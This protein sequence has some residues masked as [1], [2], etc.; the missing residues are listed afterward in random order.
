MS[1]KFSSGLSLIVFLLFQ[2]YLAFAQSNPFPQ[3][4]PYSQSFEAYTGST[5]AYLPGWQGWTITGSTST[6]FPTASPSGNQVQSMGTNSTVS[7][8]VFD[9]NGKIG[10]LNSAS[11]LKTICLSINTSGSASIQVSYLVATQRTQPIDRVGA[12]GLQFRIGNVGNFVDIGN[13]YQNINSVANTTGTGMLNPITITVSLPESC[14]NLPEVQLRWVYKDIS[15]AGGRPSFSIDEVTICTPP[16]WYEDADGD[17]YG[18]ASNSLSYCTQPDGYVANS[19]DCNDLDAAVNTGSIEICN[20]ID[21]NCSGVADE[22]LFFG[23]TDT[24]ACN[25]N[26]NA[27]CNNGSCV[28]PG[29][30]NPQACNFDPTAGCDDGSCLT[31]YGCSD[32]VA[33]N[34]NSIVVCDDGSCIY[35]GCAN[36]QAAN[37]NSLAGCDDGSCLFA[38]TFKVD[39]NYVTGFTTPEVNGSFNGYC[40]GCLIMT[41]IDLDGI[42]EST[43]SILEGNYTY[44]FAHDSW[45]GQENLTQSSSC[46]ANIGSYTFRSL[47]VAGN[48]ILP[49]VC[50]SSCVSCSEMVGCT[51]PVACNYDVNAHVDSGNCLYGGCLEPNA[52]NFNPQAICDIGN[53]VFSGC[54]NPIACN[55]NPNAG[56]DDGSCILPG[57]MDPLACN[58]DSNA[59]CSNNICFYPGCTNSL[60]CNFNP[61]AGCDDGSCHFTNTT[62]NDNNS[63]TILDTYNTSCNCIGIPYTYGTIA[64]SSNT[65]C[66]EIT[67]SSLA[68]N[69]S[70]TGI[71]NYSLQWYFKTGNNTAPSG[72]NTSGWNIIPGATASSLT[73]DAFTGTRTYACFVTPDASYGISGNWMSGAKVLTYSTFAAQTIIGNPN[74]A[75]FNAYNYI[76]NPIPGHTYNWSVTNGAIASGQGTNNVSI[77]W[78]QNGPYQLTLTESDGTCSGSSYLFAVNNN[79]SISVSAAS[80]TTNT[81]CAGTTLQ[82]QAATSATGITYQWYLNGT[83]IP[84]ETNQNISVSSGGNYQVSINQN[85]CTAVSNIVSINQLPSAII[86][87]ILVE[88]AN[89]GCAGGEATL[90]VSGGTYSNLLWN[91]GLTASSINVNA[92]GDF[93]IT[94]I[95]ENGCAVSAGPVSVNFSILDPVPVCIVTVDQ[96]TGKNNVVWEPVTSDLINSYVVLKETNVAN[97]Y[98]QIGTVAYGSSGIFEDLNSDPQIQANRYKLALIDTCGILSSTSNF[99]KTI[100]LTANQGLGSNVNLIWSDY[101]GF[102]FGSYSIYRGSSASSLNLLTTI[103]SNLNSFTDVNPPVGETYYMIEVAGV[104]CDPQRTLVYSHSNILDSTVGIEEFTSTRISL[105]PNPA[106]TSITLQVNTSLIGEEY[107]VFDAVGKVIYKNKIQSTNELIH[108]ENFNNGNYFIKV[109]EVVKRFV[110]QH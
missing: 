59:T 79:C 58:Y 2:T 105:Y 16:N 13:S 104:S 90:T 18:N 37:Y 27:V 63:N 109:N 50:W 15:G 26:S 86:P 55:F 8:G 24:E 89:A 46:T 1:I 49:V 83:L 84:N 91:N 78:G 96:V 110:V 95:D 44:K 94:A 65:I 40:G 56:C 43:T 76:V 36:P 99:H 77:M 85:G 72:S 39:M 57:C 81:F 21:D 69:N 19:T 41:D 45:T 25:Y 102:D 5:I 73:V 82:L 80:S 51:D 20:S 106:S 74:I 29:C 93:S 108:L 11:S 101:E 92:S 22:G 34:Y 70:P 31:V 17:G 87:S 66:P 6:T 9:F 14:N 35:P 23:C 33:C 68:I 4:L 88:Q 3:V 61:S 7:S 28:Y 48:T 54:N 98:A 52:C 30:T 67:S 12:I 71:V 60:A 97:E 42:F 62:C 100:H 32:P 107:I 38:V 10:F 47:T 53:C 103:A 75:P 64:S